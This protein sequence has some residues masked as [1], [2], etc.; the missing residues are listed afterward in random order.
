MNKSNNS[1]LLEDSFVVW[2]LGTHGRNF[3][4][5]AGVDIIAAIIDSSPERLSQKTYLDIP[6]IDFET[7]KKTYCHYSIIVSPQQ[8]Q[9]I[10]KILINEKIKKYYLLTKSK[11]RL[12]AYKLLFENKLNNYIKIESNKKYYILGN[13]L[14]SY[15]LRDYIIKRNGKIENSS[16]TAEIIINL[17]DINRT[18]ERKQVITYEDINKKIYKK[19]YDDLLKFKNIHKN[20]RVVII[21]N[22]PS[23]LIDDLNKLKDNKVISIGC[24]AIYKSFDLVK[25]RPT[26]YIASDAGTIRLLEEEIVPKNILTMDTFL[27]DNYLKFWDVPHENNYHRFYQIQQSEEPKF[28]DNFAYGIYSG[29]S[30]IYACFQLAVYMGFSSIYLIGCDFDY[31]KNVQGKDHF[32]G[33]NDDILKKINTINKFDYFYVKKAYRTAKKYADTHG[34]KIYNATRGGKLEVFPR[35][36]FDSLFVKD[37]VS[38]YGTC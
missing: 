9:S 4:D 37:K 14:F 16:K 38:N 13:D 18:F 19:S 12:A 29:M 17:G 6:I 2:G 21:G 30:V 10:E 24:N 27:S 1:L 20:E 5:I 36:D 23:L 22:G 15:L 7:Y 11:I 8:Y 28:S 25:W 3:V 26:Y 35:V 32:F 34:I 31:T 33:N